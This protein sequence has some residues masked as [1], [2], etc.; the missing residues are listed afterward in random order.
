MDK[1]VNFDRGKNFIEPIIWCRYIV[2]VG[3]I[4]VALIIAAHVIWYFAARSVLA[5]P[6]DV[7][8]RNYI[9]LP[10]IGLFALILF[11]DLLVRSPHFSLIKKEGLSL[12]LFTIISFYLCLTHDIARVLLGSFIM[13]IFVSTIFSNIKI[14]RWIFWASSFS[15][16]LLGGIIHFTGKLD[17]DIIMQ[18]FVAFFMFLCSYQLAK[19]LIWYGHDHL[20]ALMVFDNKQQHMKEQLK[21]DP[22]TGL[23]N[24]KTFDDDLLKFLEECHNSRKFLSLAMIDVDNFKYVNDL[25]GHVVGD[26]VLLHF[27]Q[28]LKNIHA[29]NIHTFR[30]GGDEFAVLFRDCDAKETYRICETIRAQM[31]SASFQ[32]IDK[33]S[34]TISC[35]VVC[36]IPT[37]PGLEELIKAADSALYTAKSNGRNQVVFYED[38]HT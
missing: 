19:I 18:L 5:H 32:D 4:T 10:G 6:P 15:L 12:S 23:Y 34:I 35:G 17:S 30:I 20:A 2:N 24:R 8:L 28:I 7:Y 13:A 36:K 1:D 3:Y 9:I 27:S 11:V 22:F 14:T 31:E 16:L 25:F 26:R 29:E 33:R 37:H 21:L 38:M